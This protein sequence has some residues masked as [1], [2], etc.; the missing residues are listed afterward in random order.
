MYSRPWFRNSPKNVQ[1]FLSGSINSDYKIVPKNHHKID[2]QSLSWVWFEGQL[3]FSQ[4]LNHSPP[5]FET[6]NHN[7]TCRPHCLRKLSFSLYLAF[8]AFP[9]K[10]SRQRGHVHGEKPKHTVSLRLE[11]ETENHQSPP[12]TISPWPVYLSRMAGKMIFE[13]AYYCGLLSCK[14]IEEPFSLRLAAKR[15]LFNQRRSHN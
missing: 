7:E 5:I 14:A 9:T 1:F 2:T 10:T 6:K 15:K 4:W 11:I 8:P 13:I 3:I 12:L